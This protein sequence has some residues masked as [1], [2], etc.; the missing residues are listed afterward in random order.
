MVLVP[1]VV[2]RA[3]RTGGMIDPKVELLLTEHC[4]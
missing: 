1:F 3:E 2:M 4:V